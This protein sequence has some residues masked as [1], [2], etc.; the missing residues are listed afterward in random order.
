[1]TPGVVGLIP[2]RAGS[3]RIPGKNV[4]RLA[5]HPLIA[6]SIAAAHRSEVFESVVVST[7]SREIRD[8]A[9]HYGAS[10]PF[11]RPQELADRNSPDIDWV[12]HAVAAL[13][14]RGQHVD[15]FS[16]L[17]PTSPLRRAAT[18]Q[19]AW[20]ELRDDPAADSLR[21]VE[22]CAQ[23]PAKMWVLAGTRMTPLL[24][25]GIGATPLHSR[26]YQA[27][28]RVHVQNAS[29]E[30]AR[31]RVLDGQASISGGTVRPFLT[32]GREGFDLNEPPDW[33]VLERLLSEGLAQLPPVLDPPY[34][35]G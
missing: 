23:H 2:A 12:Q 34:T 11:L 32:A 1:M 19:R 10:V 4:R 3:E 30:M 13:R 27:L 20:R 17:R 16:I 24:G 18:I 8:I 31:A 15:V 26:P 14:E 7:E 9:Q 29:L 33:W 6:Y 25:E 22:P 21:A 5:G 28:P 35:G